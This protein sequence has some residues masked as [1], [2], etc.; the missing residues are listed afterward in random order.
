VERRTG[1]GMALTVQ[2]DTGAVVIE[3]E[4]TNP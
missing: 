1:S 3:A 2:P 4:R